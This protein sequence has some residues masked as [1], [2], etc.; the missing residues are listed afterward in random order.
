MNRAS[1]R[2]GLLARAPG[3]ATERDLSWLDWAH[4]ADISADGSVLLFTEAGSGGGSDQSVYL[5]KTDASPAIRLGDGTA[6]GLS[7]DGKWALAIL[8]SK[9]VLLPTGAGESKTVTDASIAC[10][11]AKWFPDGKRIMI[12]A[13]E[14]GHGVR[15]YVLRV[16]TGRPEAITP[17]GTTGTLISPDGLRLIASNQRGVFSLF[18][19]EGSRETHPIAGLAPG[20]QPIQWSADGRSIYVRRDVEG[21]PT[22]R[23]FRLDLSTGAVALWKD[24]VPDPSREAAILPIVL[25]RDGSSYAYTYNRYTSDLYL[26]TGLR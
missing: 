23:V 25:T 19:L 22:V 7:P 4:V 9:V 6:Q 21:T 3:Q 16:D 5:R 12:V 18:P 26:V 17:E 14:A 13:Q 15:T 11:A 2:K 24:F 1:Q 20:D 10:R 8:Q